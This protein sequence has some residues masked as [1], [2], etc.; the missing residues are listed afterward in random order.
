MER[1]QRSEDDI[2]HSVKEIKGTYG[3]YPLLKKIGEGASSIVYKSEI[4][5]KNEKIPMVIKIIKDKVNKRKRSK[6]N[7]K[8]SYLFENEAKAL[9]A[10]SSENVLK[11]YDC[12]LYEEKDEEKE[13]KIEFLALEYASNKELINYVSFGNRFSETH[14][15]AIFLQI[16][17]GLYDLHSRNICHRDLKL[18]NILLDDSFK[19]KIGDLGFSMQNKENLTSHCGTPRYAPPEMFF[20]ETYDGLKAD[21]FS[22]GICLFCIIIGHYPFEPVCSPTKK[23]YSPYFALTANDGNNSFVPSFW[24]HFAKASIV[25]S[26]EFKDLFLKMVAIDPKKRPNVIE[27]INHPW[28]KGKEV[29]N[30][31]ELQKEF[32]K[33][34][35]KI[36]KQKKRRIHLE[37]EDL[38]K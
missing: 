15:R 1:E 3:T 10:I 28:I 21:I 17:Q 12:G 13:I 36:M 32:K 16:L 14:G 2:L 7:S 24:E 29:A 33:I 30:Q 23:L 26:D 34:K 25:P 4:T 9:T 37:E 8:F 20:E 19:I 35:S 22:L 18:E 31:R 38:Y 11:L 27:I 6:E 5:E